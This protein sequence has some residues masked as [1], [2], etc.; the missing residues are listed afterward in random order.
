MVFFKKRLRLP[1]DHYLGRRIY[2]LTIATEKRIPFFANQSTGQ[3]LLKALREIATQHCFSLHA[4]CAMPDHLH[5]LCEGLS[6]T[7][8]LVKFV[9]DF[10]QRTAYEFRQKQRSRLWQKRYHDHVLRPKEVIEDVACYIWWNPVRKGLCPDPH[11]FSL[12]GSQTLDWMKQSSSRPAWTP[13]WKKPSV[14]AEL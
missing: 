5:F 13:P 8:D 6:D 3:W 10:K 2:F 7:S 12:S 9:N 14:E 4:Y 11:L 1:A